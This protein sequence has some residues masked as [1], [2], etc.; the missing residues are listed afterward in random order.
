MNFFSGEER[1][2]GVGV[3]VCCRR[4]CGGKAQISR[5]MEVGRGVAY[6][7]TMIVRQSSGP[8]TF[9]WLCFLCLG[10]QQHCTKRPTA[11]KVFVSVPACCLLCSLP[12]WCAAP[13]SII[14]ITHGMQ[15][16]GCVKFMHE[17]PSASSSCFVVWSVLLLC[18]IS[19]RPHGN[20][21]VSSLCPLPRP[22]CFA[23]GTSRKCTYS[24]RFT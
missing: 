10:Q 19:H 8:L 20:P 12:P 6:V 1:V 3:G 17:A 16:F 11:K 2:L 13:V 9:C 23:L 21:I 4:A 24:G 15:L 22:A 5:T 14:I 7:L 18:N